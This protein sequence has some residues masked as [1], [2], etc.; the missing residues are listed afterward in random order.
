MSTM[1]SA[2]LHMEACEGCALHY[3][4]EHPCKFLATEVE[5]VDGAFSIR[6]ASFKSTEDTEIGRVQLTA[7]ACPECANK[8]DCGDTFNGARFTA[9]IDG[10]KVIVH[11]EAF[12]DEVQEGER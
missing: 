5:E 1:G 8:D 7:S 2:K 4:T 6:C 12:A 10:D 9:E 3:P 11:C